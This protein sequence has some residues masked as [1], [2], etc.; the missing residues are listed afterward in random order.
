MLNSMLKIISKVLANYLNPLLNE[1]I[2]E[3]QTGFIK[4]H[5]ILD[6]NIMVLETLHHMKR[7]KKRGCLEVGLRESI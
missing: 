4:G 7:R 2:G 3:Y 6:C 1:I 5:N